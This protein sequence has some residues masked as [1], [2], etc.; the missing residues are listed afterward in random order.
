MSDTEK[1]MY[2]ESLKRQVR[3][4]YKQDVADELCR[5]LDIAKEKADAFEK[6]LNLQQQSIDNIIRLL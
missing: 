6:L 4:H 5:R 1:E 2:V 3:Y